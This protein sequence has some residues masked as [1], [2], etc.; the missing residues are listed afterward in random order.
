VKRQDPRRRA[1]RQITPQATQQATPQAKRAER[2]SR[3]G[4]LRLPSFPARWKRERDAPATRP[5]GL[6]VVVAGAS[7]SR[8]GKRER[9]APATSPGGLRVVVAGAS[10][11][12][13]FRQGG[14]G[15]GTLPPR[16]RA[17]CAASWREPP[18]PVFSGTVAAG[19]GRSRHATGRL[20]RG[21]G[22]SLR[23]P[24]QPQRIAEGTG[25]GNR[26]WAAGA[27]RS[28][29]ATGRLARGRGGSLRLPS[30]PAR[31]KR[32][33]DAPATRPGGLRRAAS[34]S[35]VASEALGGTNARPESGL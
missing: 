31:W 14:S 6:R 7:G 5:G 15:S 26:N 28:R 13:F 30:F 34:C 23:L 20:A 18:A 4:S 1:P 16:R 3:G 17:D 27:G 24:C 29:H 32:E 10:G 35:R 22:G 8:R 12:R 33:R 19:A 25:S 21:R 9:D 2:L 11:S